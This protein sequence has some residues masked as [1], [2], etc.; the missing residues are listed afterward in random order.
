MKVKGINAKN[1]RQQ[2]NILQVFKLFGSLEGKPPSQKP[3]S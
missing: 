3:K 1:C 2:E